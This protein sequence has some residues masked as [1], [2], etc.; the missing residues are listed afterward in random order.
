VRLSPVGTAATT[1]LLH[2]HQMMIVII[3]QLEEWRLAGKQKYSENTCHSATLS[4]TN[5]TWPDRGS[6]PGRRCVK[7]ATNR[8]SYGAAAS[9]FIKS[10]ISNITYFWWHSFQPAMI[11]FFTTLL[12]LAV[13]C[14]MINGRIPQYCQHVPT[15]YSF[16]QVPSWIQRQYTRVLRPEGRKLMHIQTTGH[17]G[18]I[19]GLVQRTNSG[20]IMLD[21]STP[22][23]IL[24]RRLNWP[25][26][27]FVLSIRETMQNWHALIEAKC[28]PRQ[29]RF[30]V[31]H[32]TETWGYTY[33]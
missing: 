20:R 1:G 11:S 5:P 32:D 14:C 33:Q 17:V 27:R 2:Q 9:T 25:H 30:T 6:N 13:V 19:R 7:P 23:E 3:E 28:I 22:T 15:E 24:D 12:V 26:S 10:Q 4:T 21:L 8:L 31:W 29:N 16:L 18:T